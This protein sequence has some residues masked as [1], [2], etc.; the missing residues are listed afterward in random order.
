MSAINGMLGSV[1][2]NCGDLLLGWDTD[3]FPYD[4]YD[5]TFCMYEILRRAA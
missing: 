4:V 1:D 3:E 2:A 5:T